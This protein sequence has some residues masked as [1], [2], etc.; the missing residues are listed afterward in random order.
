MDQVGIPSQPFLLMEGGP[1]FNLQ[2]RFG[3]IKQNGTRVKRRALLAALITW[4]PLFLLAALQHRAFGRSVPVPFMR[5]FSTYTRFLLSIPIL[6]LAEN[7]LGPRIAD[8][9]VHFVS[10]GLVIEKDYQRFDQ[11][12]GDGLRSRDS[13]VAEIVLAVLA[14]C[15]S[16]TSFITT[17]VH[18]DTWYASRTDH[19]STFT[20]AG[21]W[22]VGFC[23]PLLQFLLLR[24]FWRV[25]LWFQFLARVRS[26]DLQLFPTHPDAAGGL[27]FVGETQR[28]FG[29][30]LFA[31]SIA[32][33]G[34]LA[35]DIVYDKVPLQNFMPAIATYAL[36]VLIVF[37]GPLVVFAGTLLR[38]KR[39]GLYEY[40]TLATTYTGSFHK[41]WIEGE[42]PDQEALLGT[43]D[44]QSLADLGNSF[45]II[46]KMKPIP[47]DPL[48]LLHLVVASLLPMVPLLLTVMPLGQLLKLL[49]KIVA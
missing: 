46:Q 12:I 16:I 4:L 17:A 28:F 33:A 26:L 43:G 48:D 42:N 11:F 24:W 7:I 14:Y 49:L 23:A 44:I 29:I 19:G 45:S 18:V 31:F 5:D 39:R 37:A 9:A 40:G 27:G 32:T 47:I 25:F 1:F 15:F 6:M 3:L 41:K 22:L 35:N 30:L 38:T 20:L 13:I 10:S 2:K 34:V 36:L 8:A 21:W